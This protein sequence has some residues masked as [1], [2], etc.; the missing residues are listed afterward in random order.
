MV[1]WSH[2]ID[3]SEIKRGDHIY[4]SRGFG[5]YQ[6]H[7]VVITAEDAKHLIPKPEDDEPF[8]VIEQNLEGLRVVTLKKFTYENGKFGN[9][10]H[11][12]RRFQYGENPFVHRIKR[13]GSCSIKKA[14]PAELVVRNAL[15]IYN[16]EKEKWCLYSLLKCNC[17]HFAYRCCTDACPSSEQVMAKYDFLSNT[18]SAISMT[19][20]SIAWG[21]CKSLYKF[22]CSDW[23][24]Y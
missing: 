18:V 8:M 10:E 11:N 1:C 19:V 20:T 15:W 14:L 16:T 4:A 9:W 22:Y 13:R 5:M 21:Y 7:A 24:S 17:E 6:H 23:C 3:P 2:F 12:L